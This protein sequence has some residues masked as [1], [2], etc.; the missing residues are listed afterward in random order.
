[1]SGITPILDTLL[2]QV[3]GRRVDLPLPRDLN[4]PV[5]PLQA[6]RAPQA[7]HSDSRLDPRPLPAAVSAER[8]VGGTPPAA[9]P[10]VSTPASTLTHFSVAARDIADVLSR[11][12]A[13]PSTLRLVQPLF[14]E[15]AG[16][17]RPEEVATRL[18]ASIEN[19]GLFYESHLAKWYRG[20]VTPEQL[21]RQPQMQLSGHSPPPAEASPPATRVETPA[22]PA[23]PGWR[24]APAGGGTDT[25]RP[26]AG[27]VVQTEA[28]AFTRPEGHVPPGDGRTGVSRAAPPTQGPAPA[29][30][31]ELPAGEGTAR[32]RF[33][34]DIPGREQAGGE[35]SPVGRAAGDPPAGRSEGTGH[36]VHEALQGVVRQQ[37]EMLAVPVLRWEG[38][39]WTG[40]F[41]AF[42]LN[43]PDS[44]EGQSRP[45]ETAT[46]EEWASTLRLEINGLGGIDVSLRMLRE[47]LDLELAAS[48]AAVTAELKARS[49]DLESRL[50][51]CGFERVSLTVRRTGAER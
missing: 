4:E 42:T 5:K 36:G 29:P 20:Q 1:M 39:I 27:N 46:E 25:A 8:P 14:P 17:A 16:S 47:Q 13:P 43:L 7:L 31:G 9:L 37:L 49:D 6:G 32:E 24:S 21:A 35:L 22:Q 28:A 2:H 10:P 44:G 11:F 18:Q 40:L 26:A 51:R 41:M 33:A 38:D 34:R 45:P 19:S 30:T 50:A 12:P 3:L 23:P 48:S 15:G